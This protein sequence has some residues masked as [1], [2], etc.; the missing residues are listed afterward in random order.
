M[1]DYSKDFQ[2]QTYPCPLCNNEL[3]IR[4]TNKDLFDRNKI[5]YIVCD[6]CGVQMFVRYDKGIKRLK[7]RLNNWF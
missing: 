4:I 5:P 7:N 6:N 1:R 3:E 2:G